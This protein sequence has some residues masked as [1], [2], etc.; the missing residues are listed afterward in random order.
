MKKLHC[1]RCEERT[2]VIG[3]GY[4]W[5]QVVER[6]LFP[7]IVMEDSVPTAVVM[8]RDCCIESETLPKGYAFSKNI[9]SGNKILIREEDKGV[10]HMD[11]AYERYHCM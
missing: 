8:C 3:V 10:P 1:S 2:K 7:V 4:D 11:P 6:E 5:E 9:R